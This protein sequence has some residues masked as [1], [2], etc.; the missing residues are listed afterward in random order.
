MGNYTERKDEIFNSI[1]D[2]NDIKLEYINEY[3]SFENTMTEQTK[4][5]EISSSTTIPTQTCLI[6]VNPT[7]IFA[8]NP[9]TIEVNSGTQIH[10]IDIKYNP[11]VFIFT[12]FFF[13]FVYFIV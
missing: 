13:Y 6:T 5:I 2:K 8:V 3:I 4:T 9:L 1:E 7:S 10:N 12:F 11:Y